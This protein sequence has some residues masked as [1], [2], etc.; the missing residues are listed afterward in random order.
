MGGIGERSEMISRM[1]FLGIHDVDSHEHIDWYACEQHDREKFESKLEEIIQSD[2]PIAT[3]TH[4]TNYFKF[5]MPPIAKALGLTPVTEVIDNLLFLTTKTGNVWMYF[6][7]MTASMVHIACWMV[8]P[9]AALEAQ[10][11]LNTMVAPNPKICFWLLNTSY[12]Q[13]LAGLENNGTK[14]DMETLE[15][16]LDLSEGLEYPG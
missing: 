9:K 6:G 10:T 7:A 15:Q 5:H 14:K 16:S 3:D 4:L 8:V 2:N 12:A 11:A 13:Q 1:S